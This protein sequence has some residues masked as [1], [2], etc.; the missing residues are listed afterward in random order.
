VEVPDTLCPL[1]DYNLTIFKQ[2]VEATIDD[3]NFGINIY[4]DSVAEVTR[5]LE[6]QRSGSL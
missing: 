3:G 6:V 5:L 2:S 4:N 1:N